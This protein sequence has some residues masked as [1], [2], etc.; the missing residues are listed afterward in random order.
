MMVIQAGALVLERYTLE[1]LKATKLHV[2]SLSSNVLKKKK[3][4][5]M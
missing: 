2:C 5:G 4:M 1:Y 3:I